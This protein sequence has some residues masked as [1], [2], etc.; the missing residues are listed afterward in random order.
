MCDQGDPRG[1]I[2]LGVS[3]RG[4]RGVPVDED[5]A[6]ALRERACKLGATY[7]CER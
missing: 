5:K 7:E 2:A 3:Y 6:R 4:G 1:C